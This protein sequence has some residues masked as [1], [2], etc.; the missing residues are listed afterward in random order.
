MF[1]IYLLKTKINIRKINGGQYLLLKHKINGDLILPSISQTIISNIGLPDNFNQLLYFAVRK[2][3]NDITE[4]F[5]KENYYINRLNHDSFISDANIDFISLLYNGY[6]KYGFAVCEFNRDNNTYGNNLLTIYDDINDDVHISPPRVTKENF[7]G[8]NKLYAITKEYSRFDYMNVRLIPNIYV[9]IEFNYNKIMDDATGYLNIHR[10]T[11]EILRRIIHD[12]KYYRMNYIFIFRVFV[13][14]NGSITFDNLYNI[15]DGIYLYD[16]IEYQM[17]VNCPDS[18][19]LYYDEY[20]KFQTNNGLIYDVQI[21][22][23]ENW[24][25]HKSNL[26]EFILRVTNGKNKL[27]TERILKFFK[28]DLNNINQNCSVFQKVNPLYFKQNSS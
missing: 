8:R 3:I 17:K 13:N 6:I 11:T 9:Y 28:F 14:D 4:K 2:F 22:H 19:T 7:F 12:D 25:Q 20:M 27:I 5:K 10:A 16:D 24:K 1:M 23:N 18:S 26:I 15:Y 21:E